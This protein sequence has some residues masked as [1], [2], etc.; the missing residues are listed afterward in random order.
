MNYLCDEFPKIIHQ[1]WKDKNLRKDF[2]VWAETWKKHNPSYEYKLWT[3]EDNFNL[4][5]SDFSNFLTPYMSY[6][7]NIKRADSVRCAYMY[8]YGG[9]YADLDFECLK[10][11]DTILEQY[12]GYSAILGFMGYDTNHQHCMPNAI[13]ISKPGFDFWTHCMNI[14]S[15]RVN[16]GGPELD[17]GPILIREAYQTYYDKHKIAVLDTEIFYPLCWYNKEHEKARFKGSPL[18][19]NDGSFLSDEE[20]NELFPDSYAVTYWTSSWKDDSYN[21]SL[22]D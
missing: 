22:L 1:S 8:K 2:K 14:M 18:W 19:N 11:F 20:K 10:P 21:F 16:G 5:S 15:E 12:K 6:N 7:H 17:T 3:D 4:I 9:V 13:M